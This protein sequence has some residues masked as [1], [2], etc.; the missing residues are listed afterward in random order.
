ML[1][2]TRKAIERSNS[3]SGG[4]R[5]IVPQEDSGDAEGYVPQF[6]RRLCEWTKYIGSNR[7]MIEL[8]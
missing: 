6:L 8:Y 2:Y 3:E 1:L 4:V 7:L 5:L